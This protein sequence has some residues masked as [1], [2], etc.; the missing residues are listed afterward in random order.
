MKKPPEYPETRILVRR[1][2]A[3]GDAIM[4]TGVVRELRKRFPRS[5]IDMATE[6]LDVFNNNPHINHLYHTNA[7]P[8]PSKYDIMSKLNNPYGDGL[9]SR[10]I[11]DRIKDYF[12]IKN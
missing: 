3:L 1:T 9:A 8:D 11:L 7:M 6:F 12:G 5:T 4:A 2:A 10:K